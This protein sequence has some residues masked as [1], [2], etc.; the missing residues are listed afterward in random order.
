MKKKKVKFSIKKASFK[1]L[2]LALYVPFIPF[3][4]YDLISTYWGVCIM[5]GFE[6]SPF[7]LYFV[8]KIGYLPAS[9]LLFGV[10]ALNSGII[11]Y[12]IY[13]C[14]NHD[15]WRFLFLLFWC[16]IL[17]NYA[18]TFLLNTNTLLYMHANQTLVPQSELVSLPAE[19]VER[20]ARI[21]YSVKKDF[22][23]LI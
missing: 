12:F 18:K 5:G 11:A 1:Q 22:C 14:R 15:I 6:M 16:L 8:P 20:R 3:I 17:L 23:R 10:Y 13:I 4:T 7:A 2:W 19:A 21:F 9:L